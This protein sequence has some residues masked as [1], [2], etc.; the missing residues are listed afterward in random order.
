M[1]MLPADKSLQCMSSEFLS[2]QLVL[3]KLQFNMNSITG[4]S[5]DLQGPYTRLAPTSDLPP[6]PVLNGILN[7]VYNYNMWRIS[8]SDD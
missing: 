6:T 1:C 5:S 8:H 3:K 4:T 7:Y 2:N